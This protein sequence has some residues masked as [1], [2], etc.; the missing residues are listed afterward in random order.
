MAGRGR[1]D[2]DAVLIA[3]LAAGA[4]RQ[5]AARSAGVG[6][7]TV[8]RR[9]LDPEFQ[10]RVDGARDDLISQTT[11]MLCSLAISAVATLDELLHPSNPP[12]VRLQSARSIIDAAMRWRASEVVEVRL[13]ALE[14]MVQCAGNR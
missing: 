5:E 10:A 1:H 3:A 13:A 11:A 8:Y 6:E 4:T 12:S 9:Q 7:R 14:S 2:A